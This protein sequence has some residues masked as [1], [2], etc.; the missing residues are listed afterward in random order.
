MRGLNLSRLAA[1][2]RASEGS[3]FKEQQASQASKLRATL[4]PEELASAKSQPS[5]S[6]SVDTL[7]EISAQSAYRALLKRPPA[8]PVTPEPRPLL[9]RLARLDPASYAGAARKQRAATAGADPAVLRALGSAKLNLYSSLPADNAAPLPGSKRYADGAVLGI[10]SFSVATAIVASVGAAGAVYV[11]FNPS[12]VDRMR[13]RSV[14]FRDKV[15]RSLGERMREFRESVE[16]RGPILSDNVTGR[17]R[18]IAT[19][20]IRVKTP[21]QSGKQGGDGRD[22]GREGAA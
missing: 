22:G 12:V 10:T 5:S 3:F 6:P 17:A 1:R 14:R 11:Y 21:E 20:T 18:Q 8:P 2:G 16:S 15:D 4:S 13:D 7:S 9:S 19:S